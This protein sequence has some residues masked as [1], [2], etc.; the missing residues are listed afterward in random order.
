MHKIFL[1]FN[2]LATA[3]W[4]QHETRRY[5]QRKYFVVLFVRRCTEFMKGLLSLEETS[6]GQA[7][8]FVSK[9][10]VQL[11]TNMVLEEYTERCLEN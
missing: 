6:V 8:L 3:Y 2:F 9:I 1:D 4:N 7:L 10:S 11:L 5:F